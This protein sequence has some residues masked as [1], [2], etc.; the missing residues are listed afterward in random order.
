MVLLLLLSYC[1]V[2][3]FITSTKNIISGLKLG[4]GTGILLMSCDSFCFC[5]FIDEGLMQH[6][7]VSYISYWVHTSK[8]TTSKNICFKI[9][10]INFKNH[11][12]HNQ[13]IKFFVADKLKR[14]QSRASNRGYTWS[15]FKPQLIC[16]SIDN[17]MF[18]KSLIN[19]KRLDTFVDKKQ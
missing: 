3:F 7:F 5:V 8:K 14:G 6:I 15:K 11:G 12:N 16:R 18:T 17:I 13:I 1:T 9:K 19:Q 2:T 10:R 4:H